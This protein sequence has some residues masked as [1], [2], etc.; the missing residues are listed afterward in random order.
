MK[1]DFDL[2]RKILLDVEENAEHN[3]LYFPKIDDLDDEIIAY[4]IKLLGDAGLADIYNASSKSSIDYRVQS[5]TYQ[6][7]EFLDQIRNPKVWEKTKQTV[8]T[9]IGS[10][11]LDGLKEV[12]KYYIT[13]LL[14]GEVF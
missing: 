2:I 7:H 14:N 9:K 13:K 10:L 5:L 6:G 11:T 1:R 4:H 8:F 12:S 3:D